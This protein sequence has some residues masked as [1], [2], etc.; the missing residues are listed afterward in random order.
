[1]TP[2]KSRLDL[3]ESVKDAAAESPEN[4]PAFFIMLAEA[5]ESLGWADFG[6]EL[7]E[8]AEDVPYMDNPTEEAEY[9]L[10][11]FYNWADEERVWVQFA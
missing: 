4:I 8:A 3:D 10:N 9:R 2:W 7:R 1:M 5:V 11:D 6:E